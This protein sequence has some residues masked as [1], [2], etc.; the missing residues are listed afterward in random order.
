MFYRHIRCTS[1][2]TTTLLQHCLTNSSITPLNT[3]CDIWAWYAKYRLNVEVH[4]ALGATVMSPNYLLSPFSWHM[5]N[6]CKHPSL[7]TPTAS[8]LQRD[9]NMSPGLKELT[10]QRPLRWNDSKYKCS[11][12][13]RETCKPKPVEQRQ[14]ETLVNHGWKWQ[15]IEWLQNTK[16]KYLP[17]L[18]PK[19]ELCTEAE[20]QTGKF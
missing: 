10:L 19:R 9:R 12:T 15:H 20:F 5:A 14:E 16:G 11:T 1:N 8:S 2:I 7:L 3:R 4:C 6:G 17:I 18:L 13:L